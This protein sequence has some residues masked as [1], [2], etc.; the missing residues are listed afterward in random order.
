MNLESLRQKLLDEREAYQR[1]VAMIE[2]T[3]LGT[4]QGDQLQEDSTL[5]N[6]PA[7]LGTE[8]FER[9]KD[10]GLRANALHRLSEID[11]ALE[12]MERGDYG[13]CEDCGRPIAPERLEVFP[14]ATTCV[15][16]QQR[17]EAMQGRFHRPIEE[18]VT[19]PPFGRTFRDRSGDP[20]YDGEDAWQE[21]AQYGTSETPQDVPGAVSYEDM[22]NSDEDVYTIV[23][24]TDALVDEN[25]EP[26]QRDDRDWDGGTVQYDDGLTGTLYGPDD[27]G[28]D[29][30]WVPGLYFRGVLP[31]K[32]FRRS[33]FPR[34]RMGSPGG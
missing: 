3:G 25:G 13:I 17:R 24:P 34:R 1:Q 32:Q 6:H 5:D 2:E 26:L 22:Y 27:M 30:D 12:R 11:A 33:R 28:G 16:C 23:E 19:S 8:T 15:E 31:E 18:Q 9:S 21:V 14:S 4:S 10:L 20:G 29:Y 7:D